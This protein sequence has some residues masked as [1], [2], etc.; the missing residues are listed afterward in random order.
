MSYGW[1]TPLRVASNDIFFAYSHGWEQRFR[2]WNWREIKR[3]HVNHSDFVTFLQSVNQQPVPF[4]SSAPA[5]GVR[6]VH[7]EQAGQ[8]SGVPL[9]PHNGAGAPPASAVWILPGCVAA[10]TEGRRSLSAGGHAAVPAQGEE[11]NTSH[12]KTHT[13]LNRVECVH[14]QLERR[15]KF[16][17]ETEDQLRII[18]QFCFPDAIDWEPVE[19]YPRWACF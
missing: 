6:P 19:S 12:S 13:S 1:F 18:P 4:L 17:R 11:H 2:K 10:E 8:S 7:P 5:P 3:Y 14:P 9:Q 15:F 16:M